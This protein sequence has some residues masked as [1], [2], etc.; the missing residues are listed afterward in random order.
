MSLCT[1]IWRGDMI[2]PV[3]WGHWHLAR[4]FEFM[5]WETGRTTTIAD[6]DGF[7]FTKTWAAIDPSDGEVF[8]IMP[9]DELSA[10]RE[11]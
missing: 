7:V 1:Q 3:R 11:T 2:L 4:L 9:G 5:D 10:W 8:V 6:F